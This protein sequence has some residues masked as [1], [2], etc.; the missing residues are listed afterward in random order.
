[1]PS[2]NKA[3]RF[4]LFAA[5]PDQVKQLAKDARTSVAQLRHIAH[6]RRAASADLAQRIAHASSELRRR[7]PHGFDAGGME[8]RQPPLLDQTEL[9]AACAKCPLAASLD[10][11]RNELVEWSERS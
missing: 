3:L 2:P 7:T 8:I 4:W 10:D 11:A 1:M 6:G 9:C 5:T